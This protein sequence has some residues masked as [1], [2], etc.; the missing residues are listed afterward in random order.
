MT[1]NDQKMTLFSSLIH[2]HFYDQLISHNVGRDSHVYVDIGPPEM[3][4]KWP[5]KWHFFD[6]KITFFDSFTGCPFICHNVPIYPF[7]GN[8][9]EHINMTLKIPVLNMLKTQK[10]PTRRQKWQKWPK[11]WHFLDHFWQHFDAEK[12]RISAKNRFLSMC[13]KTPKNKNAQ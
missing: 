13:R 6:P 11:K 4:Q 10:V 8:H 2:N 5:K 12:L 7:K 1:K 9:D 3:T